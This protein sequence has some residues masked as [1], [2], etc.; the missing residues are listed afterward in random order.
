MSKREPCPVCGDRYRG[1]LWD[2]LN[3]PIKG[4]G[5][6]EPG[7]GVSRCDWNLNCDRIAYRRMALIKAG[8]VPAGSVA[9]RVV[10]GLRDTH[11]HLG[12]QDTSGA[13]PM[14]PTVW[15]LRQE[16]DLMV[17]WTRSWVKRIAECAIWG[18][19]HREMLI[20]ELDDHPDAASITDL[21]ESAWRIGGKEA[22]A[23]LDGGAIPARCRQEITF[24]CFP[25]RMGNTI[26]R[27]WC[28]RV[29]G[30]DGKHIGA[31]HDRVWG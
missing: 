5:T 9:A 29:S 26:K 2:H 23:A 31:R 30:H 20:I 28:C 17:W 1:N 19:K 25:D 12:K 6:E 11:P 8:W 21:I 4:S 7:T 27:D 14:R 18:M 16:N 22:V 15:A 24:P 3:K 10:S 13:F